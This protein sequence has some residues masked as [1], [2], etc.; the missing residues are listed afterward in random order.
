M[1]RGLHANNW[2]KCL[3]WTR[4]DGD[5]TFWEKERIPIPR[6]QQTRQELGQAPGRQRRAGRVKCPENPL[7]PRPRQSLVRSV[8]NGKSIYI[9]RIRVSSTCQ[10]YSCRSAWR[11]NTYKWFGTWIHQEDTQTCLSVGATG[12]FLKGDCSLLLGGRRLHESLYAVWC[13][14]KYTCIYGIKA[15]RKYTK[16]LTIIFFI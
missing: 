4:S 2:P 5:C 8:G 13:S 12:P 1:P 10:G 15:G 3:E 14:V 6:P 11:I 9:Y 7:G 16:G